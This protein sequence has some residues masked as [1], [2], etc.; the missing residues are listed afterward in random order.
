LYSFSL[1][2]KERDSELNQPLETNPLW[3]ECESKDGIRFYCNRFSGKLTRTQHFLPQ[4][5]PGGILADE[6]GLGKTLEVLSCIL[7]HPASV[8]PIVH[9]SKKVISCCTLLTVSRMKILWIAIVVL[10]EMMEPCLSN[11]TNVLCGSMAIV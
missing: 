8:P 9:P 4:A 2:A 10:K 6:M 11:V 1:V 5:A 3:K 7:S